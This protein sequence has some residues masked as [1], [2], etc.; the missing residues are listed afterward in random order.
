MVNAPNTAEGIADSLL[1]LLSLALQEAKDGHSDLR[2]PPDLSEYTGIY[3]GQPWH[4][5]NAVV[6][7][8]DGL[9]MLPLSATTGPDIETLQAVG[10]NAFQVVRPNDEGLGEAISFQRN[11]SGQVVSKMRHGQINVKISEVPNRPVVPVARIQSQK[12]TSVRTAT[13]TTTVTHYDGATT[14]ITTVGGSKL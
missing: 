10:E 12:Q 9:A 14:V 3:N 4:S 2:D 13:T 11:S 6:Q 8:M 7:W 5:E 1:Q